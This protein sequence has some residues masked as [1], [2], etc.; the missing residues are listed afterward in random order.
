MIPDPLCSRCDLLYPPPKD[1]DYSKDPKFIG[2]AMNRQIHWQEHQSQDIDTPGWRRTDATEFENAL[3]F[4]M[5]GEFCE[6]DPNACV[7]NRSYAC[8]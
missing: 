4:A 5:T 1:I 2:W 8:V 3:M 7:I 6:C